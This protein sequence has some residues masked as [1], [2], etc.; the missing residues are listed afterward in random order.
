LQ[1]VRHSVQR[2]VARA[3]Q[4]NEAAIQAWWQQRWPALEKN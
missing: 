4:R 2:P 3:A 1:A